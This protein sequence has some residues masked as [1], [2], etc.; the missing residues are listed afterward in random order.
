MKTSR[1]SFPAID[2]SE[3]LMK[4]LILV[5]LSM[6]MVISLSACASDYKAGQK[7]GYSEGYD[8]GK[9]EGYSKGYEKGKAEGREAG[10]EQ[11]LKTGY[12]DGQKATDSYKKGYDDGYYTGK[13]EKFSLVAEN[14][15]D[16][17]Y[18]ILFQYFYDD[19]MDSI[20]ENDDLRDYYYDKFDD[21]GMIKED[22]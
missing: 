2:W 21:S 16:E 17:E 14:M 11:G 20:K 13:E 5:I 1:E 12:E 18:E 7:T 9:E 8:L 4:K 6:L 19:V 3:M 15:T 10:M 22:Y